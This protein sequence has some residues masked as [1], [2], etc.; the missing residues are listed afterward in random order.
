[1]KPLIPAPLLS[2]LADARAA[3][4]ASPP[5]RHGERCGRRWNRRR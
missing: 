4:I 5:G 1:M 2:A 3:M